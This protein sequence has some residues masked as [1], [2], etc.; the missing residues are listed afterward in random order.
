M[1]GTNIQIPQSILFIV[2]RKDINMSHQKLAQ[3]VALAT[4]RCN[5][6]GMV[7]CLDKLGQWSHRCEWYRTWVSQSLPIVILGCDNLDALWATHDSIQHKHPDIPIYVVKDKTYSS[8][9]DE[10][11]TC[12]GVGPC[13]RDDVVKYI[14]QFPMY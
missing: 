11:I 9:E 6:K 10:T 1:E 12:M 3:Q 13:Y 2:C 14:M 5:H 4:L 7:A 8:E